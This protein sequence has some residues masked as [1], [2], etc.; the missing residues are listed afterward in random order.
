[1]YPE[2]TNFGHFTL[3]VDFDEMKGWESNPNLGYQE[4]VD[5]LNLFNEFWYVE[6]AFLINS[7]TGKICVEFK[8]T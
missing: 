1:M 3:I 7:E 5:Q 4:A 8:R 2:F 6:R